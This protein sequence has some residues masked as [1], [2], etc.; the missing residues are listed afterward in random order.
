MAAQKLKPESI[1]K[2]SDKHILNRVQVKANIKDAY[3][4][5]KWKFC[6]TKSKRPDLNKEGC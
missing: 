4:I 5:V 3:I 2:D 6:S 1:L